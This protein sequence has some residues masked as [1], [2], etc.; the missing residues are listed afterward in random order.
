MMEAMAGPKVFQPSATVPRNA[1]VVTVD[2]VRPREKMS[3]FITFI[4]RETAVQIRYKFTPGIAQSRTESTATI[5]G[6]RPNLLPASRTTT[7][8]RRGDDR[9]LRHREKNR[10][11]K[12]R[13]ATRSLA[14][15]FRSRDERDD[16]VVEAEH[17]DLAQN[18]GRRPGDEEGAERGSA[19]KPRDEKGENA[20][21]VRGDE[22]DGVEEHPALQFRAGAIRTQRPANFV[23]GNSVA[24]EIALTKRWQ[25]RPRGWVETIRPSCIS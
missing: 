8:A 19:E 17:P 21:E 9:A 3:C 16:R 24:V 13:P 7:M 23:G 25:L 5:C 12:Q 6:S 11:M 10:Q 18:I 2:S 4:A 15:Y 14:G 22:R 20:A 1:S